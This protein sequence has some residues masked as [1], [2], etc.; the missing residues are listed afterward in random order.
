MARGKATVYT[1]AGTQG[2]Y[3]SARTLKRR[4]GSAAT[5]DEEANL[6]DRLLLTTFPQ[7]PQ[8]LTSVLVSLHAPLHSCSVGEVFLGPQT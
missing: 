8:F 7:L 1:F 4:M 6:H 2:T 3:G 5:Y